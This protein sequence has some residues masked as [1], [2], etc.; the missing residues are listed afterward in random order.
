MS[1]MDILFLL[2]IAGASFVLGAAVSTIGEELKAHREF[3]YCAW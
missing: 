3:T 1:L 2:V